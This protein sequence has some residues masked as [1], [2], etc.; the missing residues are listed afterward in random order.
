[1]LV[2]KDVK[3][4]F[5]KNDDFILKGINLNLPDKGLICIVGES[6]SGKSTL[7][8]IIAGFI[9]PTSGKVLYNNR[10]ITKLKK[11]E[12]NSY[13]QH[14]LG[15]IHQNYNNLNYLNVLENV[16]L[17]NNNKDIT[18]ILEKLKILKIKKKKVNKLSGGEQQRVAIARTIVSKS[19]F[20]LADEPTGSL[21]SKTGIKIMDIL[22]EES[23]NKLVIVITHNENHAKTYADRII[24]M[25]DGSIIDDTNSRKM[26]PSH[27]TFKFAKKGIK[28]SKILNI[29]KNN[30]VSK[31]KRNILTTI[32]FSV[33]LITLLL[34]LGI[35]SGF[36]A[37]LDREE[38]ESL[39]QYPLYI[40]RSSRDIGK[41]LQNIISPKQEDT[42]NQVNIVDSN[43]KNVINKDYLKHVEKIKDSTSS[44]EYTYNINGIYARTIENNEEFYKN[45]ELIKGNKISNKN[46]VLI[47]LDSN[48]AINE[49]FI[50]YLKLD[51]KSV[52]YDKL[53]GKTFKIKKNKYKIVGIVKG[54]EDSFYTEASGTLFSSD[55]FKDL[56]PLEI[57]IYPKDYQNKEII[58]QHLDT[59]KSVAYTD[60]STTFKDMSKT[61]MQAIT[62][63]LIA[64]SSIS[65]FVSTIMIAIITYISVMERTKE[66]GILKSLGYKNRDI[67]IIFY[68]ENIFIAITSTVLSLIITYAISIPIND[69]LN[70]YTGMTNIL[71][72]TLKNTEYILCLSI[73]ISLIGSFMPIRRIK[74]YNIID[75]LRYE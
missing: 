18:P 68:L 17:K 2:I 35:S 10:D 8:N 4:Q 1:M 71:I 14:I 50:N 43:H 22:K 45:V 12:L 5:K 53:L 61:I 9:R 6:G 28:L 54:T 46:E 19:E 41:E 74:K 48:N 32:A 3:M 21:D 26:E 56:I 70:H 57:Y 63:V 24:T 29:V 30:L 51:K 69:I 27:K 72:L 47:L 55:N 67:K 34:V 36:N 59:Y 58:K 62:V 49:S 20:I 65:L 31:I 33:G 25:Q 52:S 40:S 73:I 39:S 11:W 44:I 13:H 7:L 37:A 66:I 42:S 75:T 64:F 38:R 23:L 15:F 60:Y 16:C